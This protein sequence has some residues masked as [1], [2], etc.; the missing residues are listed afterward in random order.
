[1][2][3][4][5]N[6][7]DKIRK[8]IRTWLQLQP[9]G[10]RSISIQAVEDFELQAIRN[11]IW[12][13]GDSNE[14]EQLYMQLNEYADKYKFWASKCTPGMEMRKV[15][16]G[17]PSLIVRT[18]IS[19]ILPDMGEADIESPA[20]ASLWRDIA[21]NND[22]HHLL[23]AAMTDVLVTGDGA[24]KISI[25][26]EFSD[27]PIIEWVSGERVEYIHLHGR[28]QEVVFKTQLPKGYTLWERYGRGYIKNE[29][30]LNDAQVS[31]GDN[32][33]TS[34]LVDLSF[35]EQLLMAVPLMFFDNPK[36][37]ERGGSIFSGKLDSFDAFDETWSQ[38]LDA[39]RAGRARTYIPESYIPRDPETGKLMRAN[40]FDNRFIAGE[41]N[42]A[43]GG[44]NAITTE[45]PSIP[46]DSYLAAYM[47]ALDLCLQGIIS[48]STLGIDVKKLDN[49]DAQREKEKATLYTRNTIIEALQEQLPKLIEACIN[50]YYIANR[51]AWTKVKAS[52]PFGEY[53]NP[54]FESQIETLS[55]ARPGS[56]IMSVEAQVEELYGDTKDES[57]K[58]EEVKRIKAELGIAEMDEPGV[59]MEAGE[60]S[61]NSVKEV[62]VDEGEDSKETVENVKG[63]VSGTV[64]DS[65]RA[66]A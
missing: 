34:H 39:Q 57:W 15:H 6:L 24:F 12:Y 29:L 56:A 20:H 32:P 25:D 14:L 35:D 62:T 55:K 38:W 53:A 66:G 58:A 31:V 18:L 10:A 61:V 8:G 9:S 16:T 21:E 44:K 11:R 51:Q 52:V 50:A 7:Q 54:S 47:T 49:A 26:T 37:M 63:G 33:A 30:Y 59:N 23:K 22:I 42:V 64:A 4:V 5:D 43:E 46:H 40:A 2:K 48:P 41:D 13:R 3:W 1:M 27:Y 60:F 36:Y 45:Q 65:Q 28:L 17:L 19:V